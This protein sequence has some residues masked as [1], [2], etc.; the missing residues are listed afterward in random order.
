MKIEHGYLYLA[1]LNP[2]VGTEAGKVRPVLVLQSDLLNE[3]GHP[4]T[5]VLPCTTKLTGGNI[6][7]VVLPKN[8]AG[9]SQIFEVMIDQSKSIDNKRFS[10]KLEQISAQLLHEVKQKLKLL[11]D[12]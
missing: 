11:G 9:N 1:D 8:I 10:K 6:L 3:I 5:W 12:L 4:S 2:R 7:R